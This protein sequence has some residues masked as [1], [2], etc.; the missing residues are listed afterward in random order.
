[1]HVDTGFVS[2]NVRVKLPVGDG[3][4]AVLKDVNNWSSMI[5]TFVLLSALAFIAAFIVDRKRLCMQ[6]MLAEE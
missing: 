2:G 1:M 6:R 3:T 4:W 5:Y